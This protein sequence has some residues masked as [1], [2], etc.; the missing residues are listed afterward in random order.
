MSY[1]FSNIRHKKPP[2]Q[3]TVW[4]FPTQKDGE[5][6]LTEFWVGITKK[7]RQ[8]DF[9]E[10]AVEEEEVSSTVWTFNWSELVACASGAN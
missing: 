3:L 9:V 10:H 6:I 5:P 4:D 8:V 1:I 2:S 7:E